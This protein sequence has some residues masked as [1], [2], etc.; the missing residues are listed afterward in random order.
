MESSFLL[1]LFV[2]GIACVVLGFWHTIMFIVKFGKNMESST[3]TT[4]TVKNEIDKHW[5]LGFFVWLAG[6]VLL[7]LFLN[8]VPFGPF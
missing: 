8:L 5:R 2:V 4:N 1:F 6:V 7:V 3:A